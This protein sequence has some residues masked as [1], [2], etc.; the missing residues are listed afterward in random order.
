VFRARHIANE[1]EALST[2]AAEHHEAI[3]GFIADGK[4]SKASDAMRAHLKDVTF[5]ISHSD[6]LL[7]VADEKMPALE[8]PEKTAIAKSEAAKR[9]PANTVGKKATRKK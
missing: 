5:T 2:S 6:P 9:P 4:T 7:G 1:Y 3:V 8:K